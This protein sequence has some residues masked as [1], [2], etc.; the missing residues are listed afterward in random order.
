[1]SRRPKHDPKESEREILNAAEQFLR[2]RP[3]REM[4]VE[5]VMSRTG[6]K[7]PAF[8]VHFRDRH[9]LALRVVEDLGQELSEMVDR[10][11]VGTD[12]HND[13]RAAF[14]GLTDVYQRHGAVLSALAD[15]AGGDAQVE[16]AYGQMVQRFIDA[17]AKRFAADQA[18]GL[19]RAD[20]DIEETA[21]A[22]VWMDERYLTQALGRA[23]QADPKRV[24]EV[25]YSIWVSAV[26]GSESVPKSPKAS[27]P[28]RRRRATRS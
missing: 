23:P 19:I 11:L 4:T 20:I 9:D 25:L 28:Q 7:R 22:L 3:F 16:A 24:A 27:R 6:L 1:M 2:E 13:A 12:L 18:E 14:E 5:A 10:W 15:A 8:Y 21:R 17:T 26:Y